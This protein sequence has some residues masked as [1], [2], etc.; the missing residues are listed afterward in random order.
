MDDCILDN[1]DITLEDLDTT[2]TEIQF[3]LISMASLHC[4]ITCCAQTIT[5][6]CHRD[7]EMLIVVKIKRMNNNNHFLF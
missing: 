3:Q 4:S 6:P 1:G 2:M 5:L 7:T